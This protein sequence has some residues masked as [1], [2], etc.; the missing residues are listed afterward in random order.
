M[1]SPTS[2]T[3]GCTRWRKRRSW[4]MAALLA[5]AVLG[6]SCGGSTGPTPHIKT[7][8]DLL[9]LRPAAGSPPLLTYDTSFVATRG[10]SQTV[11][12]FY[13]DP[14]SPGQPGDDFLTFKL[15][16]TSLWQYPP[17]HPMA[18][19]MFQNGDTIT[20]TI[21]VPADTLMA[22]FEPAGLKFNPSAP[23]KL[24]LSYAEANQD[25]N[26]DGVEDPGLVSQIDLWKQELP[27]EPWTRVGTTKD[28][29]LEDIQALVYGFTRWAL[30]I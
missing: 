19:A 13:E 25:F 21:H 26:G 17:N 20:I 4:S 1:T 16:D 27:S 28:M 7:S 3:M 12:L 18:G 30:A 10:Q 11:E 8:A 9:F 6:A 22:T 5:L 24:E 2:D 29:S 14:Q 15:E 23:A